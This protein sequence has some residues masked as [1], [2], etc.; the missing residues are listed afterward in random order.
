[1]IPINIFLLINTNE[2]DKMACL[3]KYNKWK[4]LLA[5]VLL[6]SHVRAVGKSDSVRWS[7]VKVKDNL[8]IRIYGTPLVKSIV[9]V[10]TAMLSISSS[11]LWVIKINMK[12][13]GCGSVGRAVTFDTWGPRF[14]SSHRQNLL[15]ICLLSTVLKRW[16]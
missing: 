3:T 5:P 8:L 16:K 14:D 1:M 13:S 10:V 6:W 12:G 15:S 7:I 2:M 11:L 4:H 9:D